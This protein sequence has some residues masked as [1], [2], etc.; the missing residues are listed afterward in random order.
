[1]GWESGVSALLEVTCEQRPEGGTGERLETWTRM[2]QA[3]GSLITS[4]LL[5]LRVVTTLLSHPSLH[6]IASALK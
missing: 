4:L 1:M 2:F 3:E 6:N 5:L